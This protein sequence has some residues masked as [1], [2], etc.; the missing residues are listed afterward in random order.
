[1]YSR[2]GGDLQGIIDHVDYLKNLGVTTL[3]L[4]PVQ[5][6]DQ[7]KTSY[8][9]YAITDHY[10]IDP[11]FGNNDTYL[12]L[13]DVLHAKGMK[14]VMDIVPNHIGSRHHLF[15]SLPD[16]DWVNQW[17]SFTRT[18]YRAPTLLDPY[19]STADKKQF[20]DGWVFVWTSWKVLDTWIAQMSSFG[21]P[22]NII[23]WDKGGGYIG[24]LEKTFGTDYE[25]ALVWHNG[26]KL[27]NKRIGSVWSVG[28]D[29]SSTYKH[30]TQKPVELA[31]MAITHTTL[32]DQIV[33]D[34][35]GGS[36]STLIACEQT[37]R[38]CYMMELDTKYCDVIIERWEKLTGQKAELVN[39]TR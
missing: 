36:G 14:M 13:V 10:K 32:T 9:G 30:P 28:K 4:N 2:H 25:V 19:A 3:W 39:A 21:F 6:N 7:P 16:A 1:M 11:R 26:N 38:I 23:I 29:S 20:N 15:L 22:S 24:D 17:D 8:H 33:L 27:T 37:K 35:F 34:L 5:E 18:T 31:A 12:K